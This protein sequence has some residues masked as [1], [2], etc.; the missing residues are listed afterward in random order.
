MSALLAPPHSR[1]ANCQNLQGDALTVT[2]HPDGAAEFPEARWD[3]LVDDGGFY[4]S[5]RWLRSLE[6]V[7]GPQPV[8]SATAGRHLTGML[9]TWTSPEE[10]PSGLF[11]LPAMTH[12]LITAPSRQV[13]WLGPR[14]ATATTITCT[15]GAARPRVLGSLLEAARRRAADQ[16]LTAAVWPYL[17]G[18]EAL[19]AAACHP[20]AQA[21][22]HHTADTWVSVPP[23][24]MQEM[25]RAVRH[26]TRA[27]WRRERALFTRTGSAQWTALTSDVCARITP[28]LAATR[29]KYGATGGRALIHRILT[30]QLASGIA[31]HA[32][33]ALARARGEDTVRAA[34]VFYRHGP[35]LYGRYWGTDGAAPPFAYFHL[36][37]Y[38]AV[39]WAARHG[40]RRLHLSV[41]ATA[42]KTSRGARA[43]PLALLY[44]PTGQ[45]AGID[46]VAADRHNQRTADQIDPG[47]RTAGWARGTSSGT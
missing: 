15:R 25:E 26:K 13:L 36:T 27:Q 34:A 44:L 28:L 6:R 21:V 29:T 23:D 20:L 40:L 10:D 19:E 4:T 47:L 12:G 33:V 41:P 31:D 3:T 2:L 1:T 32:V 22:L 38:S 17:S 30:A 43:V 7:H 9:P 24:G 8:L 16:H 5:H 39:D 42:A 46:P 11:S 45:D 37:L 14:R 18:R 35:T